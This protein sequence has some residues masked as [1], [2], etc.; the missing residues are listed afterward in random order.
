[1]LDRLIRN[2]VYGGFLAGLLLLALL[3][4]LTAGWPETQRLTFLFLPLYILHQYEEHD[5]DRFRLYVNATVGQGRELLTHEAVF[6]INIF[7]VWCVIAAATCLSAYVAPGLGLA[8][9]YLAVVNAILHIVNT[10]VLRHYN[11][12][13]YTSLAIF[14]PVGGYAIMRFESLGAGGAVWQGTGMFIALA[15][16]VAIVAYALRRRRRLAPI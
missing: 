12:G 4:L 9:I 11:P 15:V 1:M 6:V 2:W 8:A 7:G 13:L 10:L 3:P 5:A 14:L 16:H